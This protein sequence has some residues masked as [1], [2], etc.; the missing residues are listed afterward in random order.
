MNT[1][2]VEINI[3]APVEKVWIA[4]TQ[5]SE[6]G[7]Y[8]KN[9]SVDTDWKINSDITYKC[10]DEK[11]E[12]MKWEGMEMIWTGVI[13]VMDTNK[14]FTCNYPSKSAGLESESYFLES[15]NP[16][17]TK[18]TMLQ[19]TISKEVADGY[20]EG[21]RHTLNLLKTYLENKP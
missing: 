2:R 4:I 14:E 10:F 5:S 7:K 13:Q 17:L 19:I 21:N 18:L 1:N 8:L 3:A 16:N 12:I 11:G 20:K 15:I 6:I 9:I